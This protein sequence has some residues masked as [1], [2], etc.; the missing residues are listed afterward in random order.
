MTGGRHAVATWPQH[1]RVR[2]AMWH[3]AALV[4]VVTA[5]AAVVLAQAYDGLYDQMDRQLVND[6]SLAADIARASGGADSVIVPAVFSEPK[7]PRGRN[8]NWMEVWSPDGRLLTARPRLAGLAGALGAPRLARTAP[9]TATTPGGAVVRTVS[10]PVPGSSGSLLVRVSRS[11]APIREEFRELVMALALGLPIAFAVAVAAGYALARRVLQP[12]AAMTARARIITADRLAERLPIENPEDEFGQLATVVNAAL[13]RLETSFTALRRFTADASHELRTP[14]TAIRTV[15]EVGL[16]A[17]HDAAGYRDTIGSILEE[18][19]RLTRLVDDLLMLS[20][21]DAGAVPLSR[22]TFD[23]AAL[24]REV[25]EMLGVL[26]EDKRQTLDVA[27]GHVRVVADRSLVRRALLNLL[28][29]AVKHSPEGAAI[30]VRVRAEQ[31]SAIVEIADSGAGI[32]VE[33]LT[34]IFDRFYRVDAARSRAEGGGA[35]LGLSISR[36]AVEA[37]GGRVEVESRPGNG[38][39][40][41]VV[42][43]YVSSVTHEP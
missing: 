18:C 14:L 10:G 2:L 30:S 42:L 15:G 4:V 33:H 40:F 35:G 3:G 34:H 36:W 12:V 16:R 19:D 8:L 28:D 37:H 7:D 17:S 26:A 29:N 38:S 6:L 41:R 5:Y 32:P 43:P 27:A 1:I 22:T 39:I 31:D 25:A 21:A 24:A 23:L 11:E 9:A 20:R 13:E